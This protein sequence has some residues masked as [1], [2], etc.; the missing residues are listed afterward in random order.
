LDLLGTLKT[1]RRQQNNFK[2][3]EMKKMLSSLFTILF[4]TT[5]YA[6]QFIDK[7]VIEYEVTTNIKKTMWSGS[8][9]EMLKDNMSDFKT[10][11]YNYT[12]ADNKSVYKFS[13]WSNKTKIP[14]WYK[15]SDEENI[16]YFDFNTNKVNVQKQIQ[17]TNFIIADSIPFIKWKLT[18]ENREIAG[19]N[20]RKAIGK[21]MDS[22]Y[23]FAFYTNEITIS[24]GPCSISGL[25]G[26]ILGLSI[27]R[28]Y[29][30]YIATKVSLNNVNIT[31]IKPT[32]SKKYYSYVGLKK[33]IA[34]KTEDWFSWGDDKEENL[35]LK[36][37]FLWNAF[38]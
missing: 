8:W 22:V 17:G 31:D 3:K 23:V 14:K 24:G 15:D 18:N 12:F 36:N 10:A 9:A 21:I 27:P 6:Q 20:C 2:K 4:A 16:W 37:L 34:E 33:I 29:T 7:A 32:S 30:S 19:F 5:I 25:P 38:L 11:Y 35:R 13:S 26:M 28:L 1:R